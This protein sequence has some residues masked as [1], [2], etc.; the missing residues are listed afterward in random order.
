MPIKFQCPHCKNGL[1]VKD[2]L[3]GRQGPCPKC[4]KPVTV[5]KASA[6][7]APPPRPPS[8]PPARPTP[9]PQ[10][11]AAELE[12]EAAALLSGPTANAPAEAPQTVDFNCPM[13]DAELHFPAEM[14]GKRAPCP[15]CT[16]I[17]KVPEIAVGE[18]KDW[19]NKGTAM[20]SLA[21]APDEPAPEG[22]WGSTNK[23]HVSG[24]ALKEA[25]VI[26]ARE[27][28]KTLTQ[29]FLLPGLAVLA[30]V[31]IGSGS[32]MAWSWKKEEAQQ[33]NIDK[34]LAFLDS[35]A[36]K[37]M[38]PG[39]QAKG[40]IAA[41]ELSLRSGKADAASQARD[42][43]GKA[44]KPLAEA[45]DRIDRDAELVELAVAQTGLGGSAQEVEKGTRLR[46][47]DVQ[48]L[49]RQTL[50]A[51][52]SPEGKL[53]GLQVVVR[54]L[55]ASG[56]VGR[57]HSLVLQLYVAG[58]ADKYEA[59]A[60]AAIE[61][62][63]SDRATAGKLADQAL[64]PYKP[65]DSP[66]VRPAIVALALALD[67]DVP[68]AGKAAGEEMRHSLGKALGLTLKGNLEEA[69]K[70]AR[71]EKFGGAAQF[72]SLVLV[73]GAAPQGR[74]REIADEAIA[75]LTQKVGGKGELGWPILRLA[76][77]GARAG[78][79]DERLQAMASSVTDAE[80]RGRVQLA[81]LRAKL[82]AM[83][84]VADKALA[85]AVEPQSSAHWAAWIE[86]AR[87]NCRHEPGWVS[88][89]SDPNEARKAFVSGGAALGLQDRDRDR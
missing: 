27:R 62:L 13:C 20:P 84:T 17:I 52:H 32:W 78:L 38:P 45:P 3:A 46:W 59:L 7:A 55:I 79:G 28:P 80:V 86:L 89:F 4:K 71:I 87:H 19:R 12:A 77:L 36:G 74:T 34:L 15:E 58:D 33:G 8:A 65:K 29:R 1:V 37:Q 61:L 23:A 56:E 72:R 9:P 73:A 76:E 43:F 48:K 88:Q 60:T 41:A 50:A 66:Q 81:A 40:Q 51:I 39:A 21:K 85:E 14:A 53:T 70:E 83:N 68:K 42:R 69:L 47:D 24:E 26:K 25:G 6:P 64:A 54:R 31:L 10:K 75:C 44:F 2:N 16:R 35:E 57:V 18:R 22:A 49:L 67:R 5:P 30:L 11:T 82:A 63:A